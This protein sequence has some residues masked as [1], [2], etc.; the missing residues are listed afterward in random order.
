MHRLRRHSRTIS[1]VLIVLALIFIAVGATLGSYLFWRFRFRQANVSFVVQ[2]AATQTEQQVITET[3]PGQLIPEQLISFRKVD[4]FERSRIEAAQLSYL[5]S[6]FLRPDLNRV[7]KYELIYF[8]ED[9]TE[10]KVPVKATV[11]IPDSGGVQKPWYV[12]AAGTSG[13]AA[14]CAP[15]LEHVEVTNIGNYENQMIAQASE[16][17]VVVFPEYVGFYQINDL[18]PYFIAEMEARVM[19]GAIANF[20]KVVNS[21]ELVQLQVGDI[22][23]TGYSQGGHAALSSAARRDRLD[24]NLQE[25]IKGIIGYASASDIV[26]LLSET[27]R[28]GPYVLYSY[29]NYYGPPINLTLIL[30][31]KW[32]DSLTERIENTCI[33][34]TGVVWPNVPDQLYTPEFAAALQNATLESQFPALYDELKRNMI[35]DHLDGLPIYLQQGAVDPIVY[36]S[37]QLKN[38]RQFCQQGYDV[39]YQEYP[40]INHYQVRQAGFYDGIRW[41]NAVS[42]GRTPANNCPA[43]NSY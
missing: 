16:N 26:A 14:K 43:Y 8:I 30:Q 34:R 2:D 29:F 36:A 13:L 28:L 42:S 27:P 22:Y 19:L 12:F 23:L 18:Q 21:A 41:M 24:P 31:Q 11:Y 4:S 37:T 17:F 35:F 1:Y 7:D 20:A 10:Q 5:H 25:K 33:D 3:Q 39:L 9:E 40:G 15:S 38:Q 6:T 32:L